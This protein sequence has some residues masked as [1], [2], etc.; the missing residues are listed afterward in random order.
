MVVAYHSANNGVGVVLTLIFMGVLT[1]PSFML[2][3]LLRRFLASD[4]VV[5]LVIS[6]AALLVG[7][8][9]GKPA[10]TLWFLICSLVFA[11][12]ALCGRYLAQRGRTR[13]LDNPPVVD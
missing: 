3:Y 11:G 5:G 2:G 12:A 1:I 13:R 9:I 8:G 4:V 10:S 6:A 7:W